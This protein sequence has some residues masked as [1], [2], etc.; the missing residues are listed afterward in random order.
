M[1]TV[2]QYNILLVDDSTSDM[3]LMHEAANVSNLDSMVSLT[4]CY[5]AQESLS[6]L[7]AFFL[8][9]E[10]F[11]AI[12]LDLNMPRYNGLYLLDKIKSD[13][14]FA[15]IPVFV[16]TNSDHPKDIYACAEKGADAYIQKPT[17][18]ITLVHFFEALK[19]SFQEIGA[20]SV[21]AVEN[22]YHELQ[23]AA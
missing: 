21:P 3:R 8:R 11:H 1:V 15:S 7:E 22:R 23:R 2:K 17:N 13:A 16:L 6:S 20:V 19:Y 14:R 10:N 4:S 18:F 12:I 5:S 9:G